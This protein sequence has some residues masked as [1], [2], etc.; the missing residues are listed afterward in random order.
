MALVGVANN[1]ARLA[2][3]QISLY[4]A[5][6]ASHDNAG[7]HVFAGIADNDAAP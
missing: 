2:A 1:S 5:D 7:D 6:R 4:P 3:M